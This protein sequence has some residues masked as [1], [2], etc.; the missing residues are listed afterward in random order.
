MAASVNR[1]SL[2][3]CYKLQLIDYVKLH[4][5]RTIVR[6]FGPLPIKKKVMSWQ[7]DQLKTAFSPAIP[8]KL[9]L[10]VPLA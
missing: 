3:I 2:T 4:G 1:L 9:D 8:K 5:N 7:E 10:C 6:V